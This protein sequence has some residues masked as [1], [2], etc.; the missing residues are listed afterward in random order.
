MS[1]LL[2][3]PADRLAVRL[4]DYV[5]IEAFLRWYIGRDEVVAPLPEDFTIFREAVE[6]NSVIPEAI[7]SLYDSLGA[8]IAEC[9]SRFITYLTK[10]EATLSDLGRLS[11]A[12]GLRMKGKIGRAQGI[13]TQARSGSEKSPIE[14]AR[15]LARSLWTEYREALDEIRG[16]IED[17]F[18][19]GIINLAKRLLRGESIRL[20]S[21]ELRRLEQLK[22]SPLDKALILRFGNS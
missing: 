8:L 22:R 6:G 12:L 17:M 3:E 16:S 21:I 15:G 14:S 4:S 2:K 11:T 19:S 9:R 1:G 5:R 7:E 10:E 13:L 18:E 20:D